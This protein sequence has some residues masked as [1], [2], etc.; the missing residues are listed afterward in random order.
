MIDKYFFRIFKNLNNTIKSVVSLF[1]VFIFIFTIPANAFSVKRSC[2][3]VTTFRIG[4]IDP[5]FNLTKEE[6]LKYATEAANIW[7]N[8]LGEKVLEYSETGK[9]VIDFKYDERQR[10]TIEKNI[11]A[12]KRK[13]KALI[14]ENKL[15]DLN[16][17]KEKLKNVQSNFEKDWDIFKSK[18]ENYNNEVTRTNKEGGANDY[19]YQK[20]NQDKDKLE[21][22]KFELETRNKSIENYVVTL[23]T[24]VKSYNDLVAEA[25]ALVKELNKNV[26]KNFEQGVYTNNKIT[27]YEYKD[28][29][30]LKRL[31]AH[32]LGHAL[33]MKHTKNSAS[34]MHY[35]NS[36]EKFVLTKEDILEYYKVCSSR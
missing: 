26:G 27:L 23:N 18:L 16:T 36:D 20:L 11:L 34:I 25:N 1:L 13:E 21:S 24:S 10:E 2:S 28:I 19:D 5:E 8:G 9:V 22:S 3:K 30:N 31:M 6:V 7:N 14:L 33:K 35:L 12:E 4:K 15:K 29:V 32:E 17:E